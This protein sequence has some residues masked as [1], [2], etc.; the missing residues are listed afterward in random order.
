M[1]SVCYLTRCQYANDV[2]M[3]PHKVDANDVSM[4]P[5]VTSQGGCK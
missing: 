4:L 3:L 2:S 5:H 1:M